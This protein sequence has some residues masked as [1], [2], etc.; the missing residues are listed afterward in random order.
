MKTKMFTT[1]IVLCALCACNS[2][3]PNESN[4]DY[5]KLISKK[6]IYA[7]ASDTVNYVTDNYRYDNK[8]RLERINFGDFNYKLFKYDSIDQVI[9][10]LTFS[11]CCE[12][13]G[14][15]LSDS[16]SYIY[17]D[18]KLIEEQIYYFPVSIN[19]S[20]TY[21]YEYDDKNLL[22]KTKFINDEISQYVVYDYADGVC[23]KESFYQVESNSLTYYTSN[24]YDD[25]RIIKSEIFDPKDELI[26]VITYSYNIE[27]C[28]E[29]EESKQINQTASNWQNYRYKYEYFN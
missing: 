4:C 14:W 1:L 6:I 21:K 20:V 16:T 9:S 28:L 7:N 5:E 25:N 23:T 26:R 3:L 24:Q 11:Y 2:D 13:L 17:N 27:G 10:Q 18:S 8:M 19:G 22:K 12:S 29:Y 15:L